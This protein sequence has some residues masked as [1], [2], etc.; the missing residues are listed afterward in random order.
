MLKLGALEYKKTV[1]EGQFWRLFSCVFV[2]SSPVEVV[3]LE[4]LKV[5]VGVS[6]E[7]TLKNKAILVLV[8]LLS[9]MGGNLFGEVI[10]L[11]KTSFVDTGA[12]VGGILTLHS[13][14]LLA[15]WYR[16]PSSLHKSKSFTLLFYFLLSGN[17]PLYL[18]PS[19]LP[20]SFFLLFFLFPSPLPSSFSLLLLLLLFLLLLP[21]SFFKPCLLLHFPSFCLPFNLI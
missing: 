1:L 19:P 10:F 16:K 18:L 7:K 5:W 20:S 17:L 11:Q 8:Y 6:L 9:S 13:F 2:A 12:G 14:L 4:G 21:S 15:K 3:F